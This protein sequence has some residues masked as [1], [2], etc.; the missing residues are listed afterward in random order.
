MGD[1]ENIISAI[2]EISK[3]NTNDID[4]ASSNII[5][6]TI[7][8]IEDDGTYTV[9][10]LDSRKTLIPGI[11]S[12]GVIPTLNSTVV[13][14]LQDSQSGFISQHSSIKNVNLIGNDYGGLI[15]IEKLVEKLNN[16]EQKM[17]DTID[18]LKDFVSMYNVHTHILTLSTGTGTAAPTTS[19]ETT[20]TEDALTKT[21]KEDIENTSVSHG[22]G[23]T[24]NTSLEQKIQQAKVE[25]G[26]AQLLL[27][28]AQTSL[29]NAISSL[30]SALNG[31]GGDIGGV[32]QGKV[33][34]L[35]K[36]VDAKQLDYDKADKKYQDLK[37][38]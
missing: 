22:K 29:A 37:S 4:I 6:G 18:W 14:T 21:K 10:P 32:L 28:Q 9:R 23:A 34:T 30:N 3:L 2:Q 27:S 26:L 33:N 1:I 5:A 15:I 20:T 36:E 31:G 38:Q 25:S 24:D 8:S 7:D 19:Q 12:P 13:V 17:N 11:V 16:L 35:Q